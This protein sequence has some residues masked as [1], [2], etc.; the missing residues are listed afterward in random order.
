MLHKY[1]AEGWWFCLGIFNEM[2]VVVTG[3]FFYEIDGSVRSFMRKLVVLSGED[4]WVLSG[5]YLLRC[6]LFCLGIFNE[7]VLCGCQ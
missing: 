6:R 1:A 4:R 7:S 2:S 5:F 3:C